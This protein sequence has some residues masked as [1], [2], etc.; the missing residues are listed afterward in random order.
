MYFDNLHL[1]SFGHCKV[2]SWKNSVYA[3]FERKELSYRGRVLAAVEVPTIRNVEAAILV[4]GRSVA[5]VQKK[6]SDI[7]DW[8]YNAGTSKLFSEVAI[9]LKASSCSFRWRLSER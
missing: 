1:S 9:F 8:L 2:V 5:E 4:R 6:L 7:A 3:D